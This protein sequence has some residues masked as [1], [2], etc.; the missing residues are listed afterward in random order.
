MQRCLTVLLIA[1]L[2]LCASCRKKEDGGVVINVP[3][4]RPAPTNSEIEA[5]GQ[6]LINKAFR[7][8]NTSL[9]DN[10]S[11]AFTYD[12]VDQRAY[13]LEI[14]SFKTLTIPRVPQ[15]T[16]KEVAGGLEWIGTLYV[17]AKLTGK[18]DILNKR[19]AYVDGMKEV[20]PDTKNKRDGQ[21][22]EEKDVATVHLPFS[23]VNGVWTCNECS[24]YVALECTKVKELA[25]ETKRY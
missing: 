22:N 18:Y 17:Q 8:C 14:R 20:E 10:R 6:K 19:W 4:E 23:K 15:A 5:E 21:Q 12:E 1:A 13:L 7:K 16:P 2:T 3:P 25:E 9:G 11:Y 24:K